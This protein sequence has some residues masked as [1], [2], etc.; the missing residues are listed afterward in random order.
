LRQFGSFHSSLE[1]LCQKEPRDEKDLAGGGLDLTFKRDNDNDRDSIAESGS[2]DSNQE[3]ASAVNVKRDKTDAE[4]E[5][6]EAGGGNAGPGGRS[7]HVSTISVSSRS[8][9]K[10]VAPQ[11]VRPDWMES[12]ENDVKSKLPL[13]GDDES[14]RRLAAKPATNDKENNLTINGVCVMN[15][16]S[17]AFGKSFDAV[18]KSP[19]SDKQEDK[20]ES[21]L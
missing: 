7:D 4:S 13:D 3:S 17:Y 15:S 14:A 11:W 20:N 21:I 10:P 6:D 8:R 9:R 16:A 5:S 19:V 18:N 1:H 12:D 2:D